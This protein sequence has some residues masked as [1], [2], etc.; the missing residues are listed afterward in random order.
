MRNLSDNDFQNNQYSPGDP[1]SVHAVISSIAYINDGSINPRGVSM[2][3]L[4]QLWS[5]K[6]IDAFRP[7]LA[8]AINLLLEKRILTVEDDEDIPV[9]K[10][11]VDLFR[12]WWSSNHQDINLE[13]SAI[14]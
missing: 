2:V 11:S 4:Q 8:D 14:K 7:L 1:K 9:Y 6:H 3:E 12:R 5:E 13:L 10:I